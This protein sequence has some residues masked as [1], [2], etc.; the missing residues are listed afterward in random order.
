MNID[1]LATFGDQ[2]LILDPSIAESKEKR[3]A[4]Y[5]AAWRAANPEKAKAAT[6]AWVAAN[7]EKVKASQAAWRAANPEKVLGYRKD[8]VAANHEKAKAYS[9]A[10][11]AANRKH[12]KLLLS[13]ETDRLTNYRVA[14][15]LGMKVADCSPELI[16]MKREHVVRGRA[17]R[18]LIKQ[19][20]IKE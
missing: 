13:D 8:W 15:L 7:R 2:R 9:R 16:K 4:A 1:Q 5:Q 18:D 12:K 11:M 3:V 17:L 6:K 10:W 14:C 20:R 19:H